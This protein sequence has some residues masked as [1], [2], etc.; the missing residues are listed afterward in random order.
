[1]KLYVNGIYRTS[2]Q[3]SDTTTADLYNT[4][5]ALWIGGDGRS[6]NSQNFKGSIRN[7]AMYSGVR[8]EAQIAL[9][10][11]RSFYDTTEQ[12]LIFAHDLTTA[13]DGFI[14]D[15]SANR[16]H[17]ND[18][19]WTTTEGRAFSSSDEPMYSAKDYTEAPLSYEALIY[20]PIDQDRP[21][22]LW[23]NYPN[24]A[25]NCLNFE[26]YS[27]GK[28]SVYIIENGALQTNY[29]FNYDVRRNTWV[30]LVVT[31]ETVNNKDTVFKCYVDGELVET[32][33]QENYVYE[34]NMSEIQA[35]GPISIGRDVRADQVYKGRIK[36]V[37]IHNKTLT[38]DE[39]KAA[40]KNGATVNSD[41]FIA[42]YDMTG[43]QSTSSIIT[44]ASGNGYDMQRIFFEKDFTTEDYDYAFAVVGDT[45]FMVHHDA[46]TGTPLKD[47]EGNVISYYNPSA[48]DYR[49]KYIY[50]YIVNNKDS[51][52][53]KYVFG[54]GDIID[55]AK[56]ADGTSST[57][58]E[59]NYAKG[60]ILDTLAKS[61]IPYSLIGG[62]HD[63]LPPW[64]TGFNATFG[65]EPTLTKNITGYYKSGQIYNYYMNFEV[66][67]TPYMLLALEYGANDDVLAWANDVVAQNWH[68]RVIVTTHGY[69]N[70]DGTTLDGDDNAAPKPTGTTNE[71]F[72][73]YNNGDEMWDEFVRKHA[74]ITLVLSGHI[75]YNNIVMREDIGDHGNTVH[76][77]LIDPQRMDRA[78]G[79]ET[80]MV[81]MLYFRNG[82]KDVSVEYVSTYKTA[83]NDGKEILFNGRNQ[84]DFTIE[85]APAESSKG[86]INVWLIGGQSNAV[87]YANGLSPEQAFDAR[88]INGF[89]NV[90]YYGYGEKWQS[91]F[92]PVKLGYGCNATAS[93]AELGIAA[94]LG[95]TG[96]MNAIIKYAQGA[97]ALYPVTT[98]N[99]AIN[100]GTW[101]SPSYIAAHDTPTDGNKTGDLYINFINTVE[102]AITEL[103]RMGYT[104][105]IKGM[106]WMQGEEEVSNGGVGYYAE[107]LSYLAGDV[108]SD[109]SAVMGTDMSKMPFVIG[110]IYSEKNV[111]E[112]E[113][114]KKVQEQ[115][116]IFVE[117]D[118][119]AALVSP[120]GCPEFNTQD[121]WHFD[122][123]T[124][125]YLGKTFVEKANA[126]NG[127]YIVETVAN[128]ITTIGGGLYKKGENVNI[129]FNLRDSYEL[130]SLTVKIGS[131][132][133]VSIIDALNDMQYSFVCEDNTTFTAIA[134]SSLD[135]ETDYGTIPKD[136][137]SEDD[138]PVI[139][140][141]NEKTYIGAYQSITAAANV[142]MMAPGENYVI[143]LR[144][145]LYQTDGA[146]VSKLTGNITLDLG[147]NTLTKAGTSYIFDC[148]YNG[149]AFDGGKIA[150]K[151][152]TMINNEWSAFLCYNY[153]ASLSGNVT[154]D[155][156]FED[157]H[158]ISEK[159]GNVIMETWEDGVGVTS[160]IITANMVFTDCIFDYTGSHA[161]EKMLNLQ[162]RS[163]LA[164]VFNVTINGG[165]II[166]DRTVNF[167]DIATADSQDS[168]KF[169]KSENGYTTCELASDISVS[170]QNFTATDGKSLS[171]GEG[172]ASDSNLVYTLGENEVT[173]YGTI[174][175]RYTNESKYPFVAFRNG[176]FVEGY[177]VW[178]LDN[179]PSAL[180]H[181]K[182]AGSVILMR[183]DYTN[184]QGTQ[185][186]N[187]SHTIDLIIDLGGYT[188]DSTYRAMFF[189]QKK[190]ANDT[191]ITVKNGTVLLGSNGLMTFS[192]WNPADKNDE[193]DAEWD[194][195]EG[196]NG[197]NITYDGV[198][199]SL[200]DGATT[201]VVVCD[202]SFTEIKPTLFANLTFNGC[203][204]DLSGSS[205]A[206]ITMFDMTDAHCTVTAVINGCEI[207]GAD[208]AITLA[209]MT[210]GN[211]DSS[212]SFAKTD[213]KYLTVELQKGTS[214]PTGTFGD[215]GADLESADDDITLAFKRVSGT[216]TTDIYE[217]T[218]EEIA[219]F[220]F[221]PNA[222]VTLDSN[223]IFNI[224]LPADSGAVLGEITL[225]GEKV[226]LGE[227]VDGYYLIT[228]ELSADEA[229]KTLTL[230]VN[231][232][233]S[234]SPLKG[235]F[236]F[237]TVKYAA[238]L[239]AM[240]SASAAEKTLAKDML[241]Y[242][243]SA[244]EFFNASDK[245]TVATE[246]DAVLGTYASTT[247]ID[248]TEAKKTVAGLTG[249]TFVLG[250][251][252]AVRFYFSGE[253]A[254]NLFS[255]KVGE[256]ALE[257]TEDNYNA[258]DNYVE[259]SL[260]A[261]EM[262]EVFS[263][264]VKDT[265]VAGEY[266]L[267]SYYAY[268]S[269]D[270]ENDYKGENKAALTDVTAK[271]YNYCL[272]AKAYRDYVISASNQ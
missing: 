17:A 22:V 172:V 8:T 199:I 20:A 141:T 105:V 122:A 68:R 14:E 10:Y 247:V 234:G 180:S 156:E 146:S 64:D 221:V 9:D 43:E 163:G 252:P 107:L 193:G 128:N 186:N 48:N 135:V 167:A 100:Y 173:T 270:G 93:G 184:P 75:D 265:E 222:S 258:S 81:A 50:D 181:S 66:E 71:D 80:G 4:A 238:K 132:D 138:Y 155:F 198:N 272:S 148:F 21:G 53:I 88:F 60:L 152:G 195:Y 116:S 197:F 25:R 87:G 115:Q 183:R 259:F 28:P 154:F 244:Y 228:E 69:M 266:N 67:G 7:V 32:Y 220:S 236:T 176:S 99:A 271:F 257:I 165:K 47:A 225:N 224:Y 74:N 63:Y 103:R 205:L 229:A 226:T 169:G 86:E 210:N 261:Y 82:G 44:D 253:Y 39:V 153:G 34:L 52:K 194:A 243:K 89:D 150:I 142:A 72:L 269:G 108:R 231:L 70:Y 26:I 62:N 129:I 159:A 213:G 31:Q 33:T 187:L 1:M 49:A 175:Y 119:Y 262:T 46:T 121:Y 127:D 102:S 101:T 216:E 245:A 160:N 170:T 203:S 219:D 149:G 133:A 201:S 19:K 90:L 212:L 42:Y 114:I 23:G 3:F 191:T 200:V 106:W 91:S 190:T 78:Y 139:L 117:S 242:V 168:V 15:K 227:A 192:S 94:A 136:E 235:T 77:F 208:T 162:A 30:H 24:A 232:T 214:A 164:A 104:P 166:S 126:I 217:L 177:E 120:K 223:L 118:P 240:E 109:L 79:Y 110:Q 237:S 246:I 204:F 249:A 151:N 85:E 209:N 143:L 36:N 256:R 38:A 158:F 188:F 145:D 92:A 18:T 11:A 267:I 207:I 268:A 255:F 76:Q 37:A 147:G 189:A 27:G 241:A 248:T 45:Q 112:Q 178:G 251:K 98:G 260:Y 29:K 140:F 179:S 171:F 206:S 144:R 73:K 263:Y 202:N 51:K 250:A 57:A 6:G 5:E 137:S 58:A 174:P 95:N 157:V 123:A 12:T 218:T 196:N 111:D 16:N 83:K 254:Y 233:V 54:L 131:G 84:F 264:T 239:L 185:Y 35:T 125:S 113:K 13:K 2:A 55:N 61:G 59:W 215:N 161:N 40:Y 97:T 96:E 56:F 130:K 134:S 124:Q 211:A 41:S 182:A 65:N 230:V